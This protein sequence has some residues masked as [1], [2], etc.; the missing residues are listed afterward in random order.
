[1][2]AGLSGVSTLRGARRGAR[3]GEL[4]LERCDVRSSSSRPDVGRIFSRAAPRSARAASSWRSRSL[5]SAARLALLAFQPRDL[6]PQARDVGMVRRTARARSR[7]DL[8]ARSRSVGVRMRSPASENIDRIRLE[9]RE[10]RLEVYLLL[11]E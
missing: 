4:R 8:S 2:K 3:L 10:L 9:L 1:M 6:A 11:R 7:V 5:S